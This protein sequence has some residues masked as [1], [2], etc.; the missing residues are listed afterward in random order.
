MRI[1]LITNLFSPDELA[2]AALYTDM[3]L[4]LREQGHDVWVTTTFSYYPAW[5]LRPEDKGVGCRDEMFHGIPV[6]RVRMYVPRRVTGLTSLL[7]DLGFLWSLLLRGCH[8]GRRP[9]IVV[10]A[11][12][13]L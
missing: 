13:M 2:G 10:T 8:P 9:D 6:R 11:M 1:H 7:S 3:A 12:P 5:S 4:Y